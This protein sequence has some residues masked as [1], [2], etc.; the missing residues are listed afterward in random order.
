MPEKE[1]EV[2]AFV[3][4]TLKSIWALELLL[5]LRRERNHAWQTDD[6]VRELRASRVVVREALA[7]LSGAGLVTTD[8]PGQ[9][10]YRPASDQL[11][12]FVEA[13]Q[14]LYDAKPLSVINAIASAPNEKLRIFAE[15]FRLKE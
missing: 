5:L 1:A 11:D 14:S 8:E 6:L 2:L 4:A 12:S 7:G 13:A 3:S 9:S 15:A 10:C